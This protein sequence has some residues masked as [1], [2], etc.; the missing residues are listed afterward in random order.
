MG[1]L[2]RDILERRSSESFV[3][4]RDELGAMLDSLSGEAPLVLYVHGI[5]GIGKSAFLDAF[6]IRARARGAAV[7]RIDGGTVEPTAAG[8]LAAL[9]AAVGGQVTTIA[10]AASR[11]A[12]LG[13][14]VVLALDSYERL[15]LVDSWLRREF[16]PALRDSVRV[17]LV[18]RQAPLGGWRVGPGWAAAFRA[19]ELGPLQAK[20]ADAMLAAMGVGPDAARRIQRFAHGHPLALVLAAIAA[21][22]RPDLDVDEMAIPCVVDA[23]TR[24]CLAD[25][26]DVVTREALDAA[27]VVRGVT[28]PL[29]GAMLPAHAPQDVFDRLAALPFVE[30]GRDGLVLHEAVKQAIVKKL[31]S[32]DPARHRL[33]RRAAW[34]HLAAAPAAAGGHAL[35]R[36]T[37][38]LLYLIENPVVR[39]A[40]FP[41]GSHRYSVEPSRPADGA[42]IQE[43]VAAHEGTQGAAAIAAWW[44]AL[45]EWFH[46]VRTPNGSVEGFY[47][48]APSTAIPPSL[49]LRDP[50]T[51][52]WCE[53]FRRAPV[54]AGQCVLYLRRWLSREHGEV[55]S[56]VQAACWIDVKRQYM[57]LRPRLRRI[58]LSVRDL[59]PYEAVA[60]RLGFSVFPDLAAV[61]DG[62]P[63]H[64]AILDF[65]PDSVDGWLSN[66]L[67]A[68][69]GGDDG[70]RLDAEGHEIVFDDHRTSLS[71]KECALLQ[72]LLLHRGKA[73]PR[74]DLI[75]AVWDT[76][77]AIGSNVLDVT[78][79]ALRAKLGE[80]SDLLQTVH[81]VGYRLRL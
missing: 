25:V 41:S 68:E 7:V 39:D 29:L 73:I 79:R 51:R 47:A 8:F 77:A 42:G 13:P 34:R 19:L 30:S 63:R 12:R 81:R 3:G 78:V 32:A 43:I 70:W 20:E 14:T 62:A 6:A 59:A 45:P 64:T 24:T 52:L 37:A 61:L 21:A 28:L 36:R 31:E 80:R 74:S 11:L 2:V 75:D 76:D 46:V 60:T 54:P 56:P 50:V 35:W 66:L 65:G 38:D 67:A 10:Q 71:P 49:T 23:L 27:S 15:L 26:D 48:M 53:H 17:L 16:V 58:A 57:E 69:L 33:L 5:P 18:G 44:S 9:G 1:A 40:F 72:Q 55:P 22:E 4:R